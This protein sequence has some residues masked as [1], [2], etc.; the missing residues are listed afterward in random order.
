MQLKEYQNNGQ[1]KAIY[2]SALVFL[3]CFF[4]QLFNFP[5][6][7]AVLLGILFCAVIVWKSRISV[8]YVR[9]LLLITA[10]L[11]YSIIV[12]KDRNT[13]LMYRCV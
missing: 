8:E 7:L 6:K 11:S 10:F 12:G 3:W 5:N 9:K 1:N 4:I 2:D 13:I